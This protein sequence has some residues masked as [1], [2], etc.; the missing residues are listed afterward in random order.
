MRAAFFSRGNITFQSDYAK[1]KCG[2]DNLLIRVKAAAINP[3]DY[4]MGWPIKGP[5][6]GIDVAGVI[7]EKGEKVGEEFKV[8]DEVY[9]AA[10]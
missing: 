5:V 7:E 10:N 3:V 2:A 1:P 8:G 4:K 9:G 6:L